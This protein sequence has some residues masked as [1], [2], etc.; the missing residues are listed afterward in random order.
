MAFSTAQP[1]RIDLD[2]AAGLRVEPGEDAQQRRLP[3]AARADDADELARRDAQV[4]VVERDAREPWRAGIF[5]AQ[6]RDLDRG[7]APLRPS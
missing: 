3:A 6:A 1:A 5:L 4:D 2:G 7:A